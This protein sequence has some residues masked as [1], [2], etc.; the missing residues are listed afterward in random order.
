MNIRNNNS[1]ERF[2]ELE[3][4]YK[5][6]KET[7]LFWM[8]RSSKSKMDQRTNPA[9]DFAQEEAKENSTPSSNKKG[10]YESTRPQ[11][12]DSWKFIHPP[13]VNPSNVCVPKQTEGML[14]IL[15]K[16]VHKGQS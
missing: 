1:A 16:G 13:D 6:L 9:V 11:Q 5:D 7:S 8:I 3:G 2:T 14:C 4:V 15:C 10:H 12:M